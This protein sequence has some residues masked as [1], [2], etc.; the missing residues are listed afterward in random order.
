MDDDT[1]I[2]S[3]PYLISHFD[4]HYN[5]NEEVMI[6][7]ISDN[8]NQIKNFGL[9]P[10][11]GG[12]IFLS[13]PLAKSLLE[14]GVWN[15][16]LDTQ[17]DQGDQIVNDCL[18]NFSKVRPTFDLGLNQMDVNGDVSGYF[19]SGRRFL[20]L[21]HWKTWFSVDIPAVANVSAACGDE[22]ILQRWQFDDN[23]VLSNGYSI[24]E[25]PHGIE[26]AQGRPG[27][28]LNRVERTWGAENF[29]WQ[30]HIGPLRDPMPKEEKK[31]LRMVETMEMPGMG[32][33]QVYVEHAEQKEG[34]EAMDRVVELLWL[35][36]N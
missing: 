4:M 22:C 31:Q 7:A 21:H 28:D 11:G 6:A 30:H 29:Q 23:I 33:R 14:P 3:L 16:C 27:V 26:P 24:Q 12:G 25:Y 9:I 5:A 13:V 35:F 2:P 20:T 32:M 10:Y 15:A 36:D 18:N 1:F 17:R 34:S 19:E 8:L